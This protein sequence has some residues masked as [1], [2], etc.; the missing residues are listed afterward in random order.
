MLL[1][2][3]LYLLP[4]ITVTSY[5]TLLVSSNCVPYAPLDDDDDNNVVV[6]INI[7]HT[8]VDCIFKNNKQTIK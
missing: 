5:I 8:K 6:V 4:R 7:Q 1:S 3:Q 2:S